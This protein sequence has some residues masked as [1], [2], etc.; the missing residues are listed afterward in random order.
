MLFRS[1]GSAFGIFYLVTGTVLLIASLLAGAL[2]QALGPRATF[3]AGAAVCAAAIA[4]L[5]MPFARGATRA[6]KGPQ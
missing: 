1:R 6:P 5:A 4:C 2:W 3:Y